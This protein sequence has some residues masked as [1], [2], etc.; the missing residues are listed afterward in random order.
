MLPCL[1]PLNPLLPAGLCGN[2]NG[3]ESDDLKTSGG[4]VEATGAS[5]ANSWKAQSSCQDKLDWLDDPC[6]LNIEIGEAGTADPG[7]CGLRWTGS[8]GPRFLREG[9]VEDATAWLVYSGLWWQL[10]SDSAGLHGEPWVRALPRGW[11][12]ALTASPPTPTRHVLLAVP[13]S[14]GQR[15]RKW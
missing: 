9:Q 7:Q 13:G 8:E 12:A 5:F 4:L 6:S 11:P 14:L 1:A 2:F 15:D 3:L 10:A